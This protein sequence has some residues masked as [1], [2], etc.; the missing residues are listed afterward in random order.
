[1]ERHCVIRPHLSRALGECDLSRDA[2]LM[3]L[4]ALHHT[5]PEQAD[6]FRRT[7]KTRLGRTPFCISGQR[8][9]RR[10]AASP[11]V[12][13]GRRDSTRLSFRG[14]RGARR[15]P[16]IC[17]K[18][19]RPSARRRADKL[20]DT[21]LSRP[22]GAETMETAL[23]G[24]RSMAPGDR[25]PYVRPTAATASVDRDAFRGVELGDGAGETV[26]SDN[27]AATM[28]AEP[29][30]RGTTSDDAQ[31]RSRTPMSCGSVGRVR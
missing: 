3:V 15:G 26:G 29:H 21:M 23:D 20:G 31:A 4:F 13:R 18:P 11:D 24:L 19:V 9:R 27:S 8:A 17:E 5:L 1:M 25:G 22:A 16:S 12:R 30:G 14:K 2:L 6:R 28:P 10:V 7:R